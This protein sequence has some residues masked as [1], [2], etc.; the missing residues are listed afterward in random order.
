MLVGQSD[1]LYRGEKIQSYRR[2][3]VV[4]SRREDAGDDKIMQDEERRRRRFRSEDKRGMTFRK[5]GLF[6]R[7][8]ICAYFYAFVK[9]LQT[10]K[11][12]ILFDSTGG[13]RQKVVARKRLSACVSQSSSSTNARLQV[14]A[15]RQLL[16]LC[17]RFTSGARNRFARRTTGNRLTAIGGAT[18]TG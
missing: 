3:D 17:V 10:K 1:D 2:R 4:Q 11:D 16:Q 6:A 13:L 14:S 18:A 7:R 9:S 12:T 8:K 15:G 5:K